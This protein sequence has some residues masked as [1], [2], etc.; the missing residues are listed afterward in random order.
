MSISDIIPFKRRFFL[1]LNIQVVSRIRVAYN[2]VSD[3]L[4]IRPNWIN[5]VRPANYPV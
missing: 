1:I 3:L 5:F 4:M 2:A